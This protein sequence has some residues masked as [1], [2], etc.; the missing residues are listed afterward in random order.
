MGG[1]AAGLAIVAVAC[2]DDKKASNATAAP[3]A[4]PPAAR[5]APVGTRLQASGV[6]DSGT[7]L[8]VALASTAA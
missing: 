6:G 8:G 1:A 5:R 3:R 4:G 2:G 7:G